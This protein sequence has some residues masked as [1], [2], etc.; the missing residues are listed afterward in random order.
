M[1]ANGSSLYRPGLLKEDQNPADPPL[2]QSTCPLLWDTPPVPRIFH[3]NLS[4]S[5]RKGKIRGDI[6]PAIEWRVVGNFN[7]QPSFP[8]KP[9]LQVEEGMW[10]KHS[11]ATERWINT[12][13]PLYKRHLEICFLYLSFSP[14][15]F[16]EW[17]HDTENLYVLKPKSSRRVK[18][19]LLT[20]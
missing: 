15:V 4:V 8:E 19:P 13:F 14:L 20:L 10:A 9:I 18:I 5:S 17:D 7:C 16:T 12:F 3:L 2:L 11:S 1:E 6:P